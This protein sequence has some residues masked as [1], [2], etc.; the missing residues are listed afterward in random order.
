VA[1]DRLA[2]AVRDVHPYDVPEIIALPVL[3]GT[4]DYLNWIDAVVEA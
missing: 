3:A 1:F 2:A 4:Q